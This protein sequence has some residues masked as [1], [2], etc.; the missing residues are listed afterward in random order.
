VAAILIEFLE[1][2]GTLW[3]GSAG[4][5]ISG[6]LDTMNDERS[7]V[8]SK[9]SVWL[10]TLSL[11]LVAVIAVSHLVGEEKEGKVSL[12]QLPAAVKATILKEAGGATITEIEAE[13]EGGA[14]VYEAVWIAN[15]KEVEI[16][17]SPDG[18]LLG[19]ETEEGEKGEEEEEEEQAIPLEQVPAKA[20]EALTKLAG[21]AP[22]IKVEMEKE[23][24]VVLYEATWKVNGQEGEAVVTADGVL[25][26]MEQEVAASAMPAAVK[27][28]ANRLLPNAEGLEVVMKTVVMYEVEG[29]VAGK[30]RKVM[31]SPSGKPVMPKAGRR[32]AGGGHAEHEEK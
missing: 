25:V 9:R 1:S 7:S 31:I 18:K 11:A 21:G 12:D 4:C 19:R 22:I 13:T 26:E 27:D 10:G 16:K 8:M 17:V 28:T 32:P 24:A 30:E 23:R 20:R 29:K 3:A 5:V 2:V 15:G 6:V 14:T